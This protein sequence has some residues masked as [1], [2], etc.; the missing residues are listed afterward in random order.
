MAKNDFDALVKR[1]ELT[2][3]RQLAAL[4]QTENQLKAAKQ[5]QGAK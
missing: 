3:D 4:E 1:L 2:R 5:L